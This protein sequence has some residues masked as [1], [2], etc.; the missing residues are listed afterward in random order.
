M[1]GGGGLRVRMG[2][3]GSGKAG[4]RRGSGEGG[5]GSGVGVGEGIENGSKGEVSSRLVGIGFP[6]NASMCGDY[7]RRNV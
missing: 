2:G 4:G 7:E 6:R 1:G 3:G 5:N